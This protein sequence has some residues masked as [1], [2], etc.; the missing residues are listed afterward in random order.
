[1]KGHI[2]ANE[3]IDIRKTPFFWGAQLK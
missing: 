2:S 1:M 3:N